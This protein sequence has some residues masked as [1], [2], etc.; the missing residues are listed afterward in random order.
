MSSLA[1]YTKYL[2]KKYFCV[3]IARIQE[4]EM[5]CN[6]F[7]EASVHLMLKPEKFITIK[8]QKFIIIKLQISIIHKKDVTY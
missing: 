8:L 7:F 6:S 1:N 3:N 2:I 5:L 4:K